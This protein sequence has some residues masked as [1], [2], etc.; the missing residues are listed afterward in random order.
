M[1]RE[2][3]H[4]P[5][6]A[7]GKG[8]LLRVETVKVTHRMHPNELFDI[9]NA[10]PGRSER[11]VALAAIHA[12]CAQLVTASK[13]FTIPDVGRELQQRG[14]LKARALYN[15]Q[16]ADYRALIDAWRLLAIPLEPRADESTHPRPAHRPPAPVTKQDILKVALAAERAQRKSLALSIRPP[17][18]DDVRALTA[19]AQDLS[20]EALTMKEWRL[21]TDGNVYDKQGRVVFS[22]AFIVAVRKIV[23]LEEARNVAKESQIKYV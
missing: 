23:A 10:K 16:A 20:P 21:G 3:A 14:I 6:T 15:K 2:A 22:C 8:A 1:S 9:L 12:I 19:W 5:S 11:R 17:Q 18:A 4:H 13:H 7:D